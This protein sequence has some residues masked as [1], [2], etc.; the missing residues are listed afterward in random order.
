MG[1]EKQVFLNSSLFP[2][3]EYVYWSHKALLKVS[4]R[5]LRQTQLLD[6]QLC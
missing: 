1:N 3:R 6:I 5:D 2:F 4:G